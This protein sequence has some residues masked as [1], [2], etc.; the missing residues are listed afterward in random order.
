[1]KRIELI[2]ALFRKTNFKN[3]LEIGCYMG[4]TFFPVKAKNKIA[5]DPA[6][7]ILFIREL[8]IWII[9]EPKNLRNKYFRETSDSFFKK[10]KKYLIK[11]GPLDVV[12]V[13]GLHTFE[14]SLKDVLN[15]LVYLNQKGVIVMH[16]CY[17]PNKAAALPTVNFPTAEDLVGVGGWTGAW[18]GDV[19]KTV[20]YLQR[21]FSDLLDICVIN[22]DNG[23]GIIRL[24]NSIDSY[25]LTI[26]SNSFSEVNAL[27]Y[28]DLVQNRDEMLN[29]IT[30]EDA[31]KIIEDISLQSKG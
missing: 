20:N 10:R 16:D 1:M 21:N 23:L 17:P 14:A 30:I 2:Q 5:V 6:F 18:C 9:K 15:A 7:H 8:L 13:D 11:K 3:Y 29:L 12:F 31:H 25:D 22:S 28:D 27:T 4:R 26:D 19:W 24:K